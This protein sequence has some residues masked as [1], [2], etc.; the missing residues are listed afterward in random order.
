MLGSS[1]MLVALVCFTLTILVSTVAAQGDGP[2][3]QTALGTA[4]IYQGQLTDGSSLANGAY[5]F[6]FALYDAFS[7][8]AQ[9]GS[10]VIRNDVPVSNGIF[11]VMLD[12]GASAFTGDARWLEIRVRPG[13]SS[14]SYTTLSPR[15]PVTATPYALY[16]KTVPWSGVTGI[17]AGFAD[18]VDNV[19]WSLTG[20][21]GTTAG[22]NFIGTTDNVALEVKV[23]SARAL[24]VEPNATSPNLIGGSSANTVTSGVAGATIGGGGRATNDCGAGS[25]PCANR[26]TDDFG[27]V[28]GGI[29]N[30]A[31]N[32]TGATNDALAA[33]VGGGHSNTASSAYA[34]ISGGAN[35]TASGEGTTVSGGSWNT[36]SGNDATVSGGVN[37]NASGEGATIGGG[38]TNTASSAQ[39]TVGGGWRNT[40]NGERATIG[41]GYSNIASSAYATIGGG[42][43]NSA[44]GGAAAVGGGVGNTA[45]GDYTT[46]GGGGGNNASGYAATVGGGD[47]NT[48]RGER[49]TVGGGWNNTASAEVSTVCGGYYNTASGGYATVGGGIGNTASSGRATVSGGWSNTASGYVATVG[50]GY[51]NTA[52]GDYATVSGGWINTADAELSTVGGGKNNIT[53]GPYATIDGG[54]NNIASGYY[55]TIGGGK[56]N[57]VIGSYAT[58]GGG[59]TN[60]ASS[61][62]STVGGGYINTASGYAA[63]VGGGVGNTASGYYATVSGG[64]DNT[65]AGDYSFVVGRRGKNTDDLHDGVFLFADS[66]NV[67]F[68]STAANQFRVRATGGVEFVTGI[69]GA[70]NPTTGAVLPSGSGSWAILSDRAAKERFAAVDGREILARLARLPIYTWNYRAQDP[71]IRHI[72]P[73][74]QDFYT[75]FQVGE[76]DTHIATVDA[77]GVALAAIQGLYQVT[78]EQAAQIAELEAR[79]AALEQSAEA[80]IAAPPASPIADG[81]WFALG[82]LAGVGAF[83][84]GR[85]RAE[86]GR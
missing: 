57:N 78:Q 59:D 33:T 84:L 71:A 29:G 3:L 25:A 43:S 49:A 37:N 23:N 44:S 42:G 14:G 18:G 20:N 70:G 26:V 77:D 6:E 55:A 15:Q 76:D 17:P 9:V 60:T 19:G 8:G 45:S 47:A 4:F 74:A 67:D 85:R 81:V 50:G 52:N 21:S 36:A 56:N 30:R 58:V 86:G 31:G 48:A 72:G 41:G 54:S 24:R 10:T 12:F 82:V 46:V 53:F 27:V 51:V 61:N 64:Y 65:A 39:A 7:G 62:D 1:R 5:D 40:A 69:D 38:Y 2:T 13:A 79:L 80:G 32:N 63:T 11:T 83:W 75:A 68:P 66:N 22:T 28:G 16:A 73:T 34:T 35:N